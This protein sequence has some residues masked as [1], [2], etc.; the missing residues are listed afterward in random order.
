MHLHLQ[1]SETINNFIKKAINSIISLSLYLCF[2][3]IVLHFHNLIIRPIF[4]KVNKKYHKC[5]IIFGIKRIFGLFILVRFFTFHG[6]KGSTR[7]S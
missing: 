7:I 2:V 6:S 5:F 4:Q 3:P 1:I